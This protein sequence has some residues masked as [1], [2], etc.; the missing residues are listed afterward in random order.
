ME[1]EVF[2]RIVDDYKCRKPI[3]FGLEHDEVC[4]AE[5]IGD[6]ENMLQIEFSEKYKQFLMNFGGGY[7]GYANVYSLDKK[8]NFYLLVHNDMPVGN[9][10]RYRICR[11]S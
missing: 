10:L 1:Y 3:L 9:Y 6:F 11:H 7:F 2:E 5:Q 4:S 8:S